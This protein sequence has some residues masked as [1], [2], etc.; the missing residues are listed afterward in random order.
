MSR[1]SRRWSGLAAVILTFLPAILSA[2]TFTVVNL[3]GA[4]EGLND[5]TPT[6]AVGG[7]TGITLGAQ[8]LIAVENAVAFWANLLPSSVDIRVQVQFNPLTCT[9]SSATLGSA[10]ALNS[11]ANFVG[12]PRADTWYPIALANALAGVD[13]D[14]GNNDI[15]VRINSSL[16][17]ACL[18][19]ITG[20]YYGLDGNEPG[21]TFD[22]QA[23]MLHELAHGLGF[24]TLV[25][26]TTGA[27][28]GG[29]DDAYMVNLEDH[30]LGLS[31]PNM[32]DAQRLASAVDNSDLHFTGPNV[33]AA[34]GFLSAGRHVGSGHVQAYAPTTLVLGSSVSHFDTA[35]TPSD[36]MEPILSNNAQKV[37][38]IQA[39]YDIGWPLPGPTSTP[40]ISPTAT[41]ASTATITATPTQTLTFSSTRTA[42]NS[43]TPTPTRTATSTA[44]SSRTATM[45]PTSTATRTPTSTATETATRTAT[46]TATST[47]TS[48]ATRTPTI[49][50]TPTITRTPTRTPTSTPSHSPSPTPTW[51]STA[52]ISATPTETPTETPTSTATSTPSET[53]TA[54]A[55]STP[56]ETATETATATP[57]E[58]PTETPTQTPTV[59]PTATATA[60]L[61]RLNQSS[62]GRPGGFACL[63]GE[64]Q[65]G[66]QPVAALAT[67]IED[68]SG[69]FAASSCAIDP[70]IGP[71]SPSDKSLSLLSSP[72]VETVTINGNANL[73]PDSWLYTCAF[74]IA[75]TTGP[76]SYTLAYSADAE[77][78]NANLL[79][80]TSEDGALVV[81]ECSGDCDGNG[82]V[83]PEELQ[84]VV[85]HFLGAPFPCDVAMPIQSC[86]IADASLDG[87]VSLGEVSQVIANLLNGCVP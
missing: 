22:L 20:F 55:T 87:V 26:L 84:R 1:G 63:S 23:V 75:P 58:T 35:V 44:T 42:T 85:L 68:V 39:M 57:S 18:G 13:I 49:T 12:A 52:T 73:I 46:R 53:P 47:A 41:Q 60:I 72:G 78:P 54:T 77:D 33:V 56:T 28:A 38:L 5:T 3:D 11:S 50:H 76:G 82:S 8:R 80:S 4:G 17:S 25:N 32:N 9:M 34:G 59:T 86:P 2:T 45:T 66:G 6:V 81:S 67:V 62:A 43:P 31:W 71:T 64:L 74:A 19:G 51:T 15:N 36:L 79:Q 40:T 48:T 69:N 83:S 70:A 37:L 7:N 24:A 65:T 21:G 29:F 16:D 30:S 27:R 61:G 10:G 14:P